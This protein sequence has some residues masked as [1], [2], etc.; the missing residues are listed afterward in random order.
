[1]DIT[2]NFLQGILE[3]FIDP[4]TEFYPGIFAIAILVFCINDIIISAYDLIYQ[5]SELYV[6]SKSK[7]RFLIDEYSRAIWLDIVR[8]LISVGFIVPLITRFFTGD[9]AFTYDG[10][11]SI[12]ALGYAFTIIN[13][14][15]SDFLYELHPMIINRWLRHVSGWVA[16]IAYLTN[17]FFQ[18]I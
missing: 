5:F 11:A 2:F 8:I 4:S 10:L 3:K 6:N 12:I 15:E 13:S 18:S 1:M 17:W 9:W 7:S 14:Q 16:V